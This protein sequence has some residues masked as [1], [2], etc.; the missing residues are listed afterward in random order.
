MKKDPSKIISEVLYETLGIKLKQSEKYFF[1]ELYSK[2]GNN[3][4]DEFF[5]KL[6]T[7]YLDNKKNRIKLQEINEKFKKKI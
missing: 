2:L 3:C 5:S 1:N 7:R 6:D 4:T